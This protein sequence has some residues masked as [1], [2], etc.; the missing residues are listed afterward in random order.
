MKSNN[1]LRDDVDAELGWS[2]DL[3]EKNIAVTTD[4][5]VVALTGHVSSYVEK[6]RAELAAKRVAGVVAV[7]NDLEV[8]LPD[9]DRVTDPELAREAV[10]AIRQQVPD[11]ASSVQVLVDHGF[12]TLEGE[13]SW[14][15]QRDAVEA[16]VRQLRGAMGLRNLIAVKPHVVASDVKRS[17]T[18]TLHRRSQ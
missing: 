14:H 7:A 12:I 15:F 3:D 16:V 6:I 11:V 4:G 10:A 8:R 5:G 2:P 9:R 17:I 13:L 1:D 18:R